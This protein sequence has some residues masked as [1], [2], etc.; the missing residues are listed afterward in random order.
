MTKRHKWN[1]RTNEELLQKNRPR[2]ASSK[3]QLCVNRLKPAFHF[4]LVSI[5][6]VCLLS[7]YAYMVMVK[8]LTCLLGWLGLFA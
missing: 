4:C 5:F 8:I 3:L 7:L 6:E 1:Q 2:N